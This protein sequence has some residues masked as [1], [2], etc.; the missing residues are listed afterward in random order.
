LARIKK[1]EDYT[2]DY[3]V[4]IFSSFSLLA[5]TY[6]G[7]MYQ[8]DAHIMAINMMYV[9]FLLSGLV[10]HF[11]FLG[12]IKFQQVISPSRARNLIVF[13]VIGFV[14]VLIGQTI[15]F[16]VERGAIVLATFYDELAFYF[17][18]AISESMFF[19][20]LW[21]SL[22]EHFLPP[23]IAPLVSVPTIAG[24]FTA[25]HG[26]VYGASVAALIAV[27]ISGLILSALYYISRRLSVPMVIHALVNIIVR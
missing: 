23:V 6:I 1:V 15:A 18:A 27:L 8:N 19:L 21:Q 20:Y 5:N 4:L 9:V 12:G 24:L 3:L 7:I 16:Q 26:L 11:V 17:T 13:V 10:F 22:I 25:Y 2:L 14:C